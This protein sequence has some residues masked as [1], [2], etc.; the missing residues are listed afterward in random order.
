[1]RR[2]SRGLI[3]AF[4]LSDFGVGAVCTAACACLERCGHDFGSERARED[5]RVRER[6]GDAPHSSGGSRMH[7]RC[8]A[9]LCP[10]SHHACC[11]LTPRFNSVW[12]FW[13]QSCSQLLASSES[14]VLPPL[15]RVLRGGSRVRV[16]RGGGGE[17]RTQ[18]QR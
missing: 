17:L 7:R 18:E 14:P 6:V 13:L 15:Q 1:M 10:F 12:V 16:G 5:E 11:L 4:E 8:K 2:R 3:L 9:S